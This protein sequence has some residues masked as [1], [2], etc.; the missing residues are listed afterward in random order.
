MTPDSQ[1]LPTEGQA[2][3]THTEDIVDV[4][5]SEGKSFDLFSQSVARPSARVQV[6]RDLRRLGRD[7]DRISRGL[8]TKLPIHFAS[9]GGIILRGYIS[10]LTRSKDYKTDNEKHLNIF[11]GKLVGKFDID[12]TSQLVIEAC[13]D[14]LKS[15]QRHGRYQLKKKYFNGL[16]TNEIPNETPMTIM[17]DD[18]RN[19]L[20]TMR[21]SQPHSV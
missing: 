14:M 8:H 9:E 20:V 10:I 4:M 1:E 19:K 5:T 13:T 18:Q 7:L 15:Q 21:S 12:T 3:T 6:P 16:A 2:T 11:I 17:N